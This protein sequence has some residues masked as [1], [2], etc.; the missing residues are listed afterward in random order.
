MA[1][2]PL[3]SVGVP[4]YNSERTVE[5]ALDTLLSQTYTNIE[6]IV[7]DNCSTDHT[8]AI[9][10]YYQSKDSRIKFFQQAE[11]LG[12]TKNFDFVL[13]QAKGEYFMWAAGDDSRSNDFIEVNYDFLMRNLDSVASTSPNI[14]ENQLPTL[15]NLVTSSLEIDQQTRFQ[16][17][18]KSPGSS[19][20]LF[21]SLIRTE[22]IRSCPFIPELFFGWDWAIILHLANQGNIHRTNS[23]LATFGTQGVSKQ[24]DVYEFHGVTGIWKLFPFYRFN[25]KVFQITRSWSS[26]ERIAVYFLILR[27]NL[28]ALI[29]KSTFLR[30]TLGKVKR[31]LQ[32]SRLFGAI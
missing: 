13:R 19:H 18:F 16:T 29:E 30:K 1:S 23:G 5:C 11:N 28:R 12:P 25:L 24:K 6:I 17:F 20:G 2:I 32:R 8:A 31:R 15:N 9:C 14:L 4:L 21:Y 7:S 26:R 22:A 10:K 27:L 3:I